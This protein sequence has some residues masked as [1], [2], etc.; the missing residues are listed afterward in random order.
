MNVSTISTKY[1]VVIPKQIRKTLKLK[2]GQ[3]VQ[4]IAYGGRIELVPVIPVEKAR[5]IFTGVDSTIDRE[6]EERL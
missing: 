5:G 4:M 1:Q 6:D 3:K 2:P